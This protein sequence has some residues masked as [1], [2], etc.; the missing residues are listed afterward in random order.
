MILV[1]FLLFLV[2]L[3][4]SLQLSRSFLGFWFFV[5]FV[6]AEFP[7]VDALDIRCK[8]GPGLLVLVDFVSFPLGTLPLMAKPNIPRFVCAGGGGLG[9]RVRSILTCFFRCEEL[10]LSGES[11][12]ATTSNFFFDFTF[13]PS[14]FFDFV[15]IVMVCNAFITDQNSANRNASV[16]PVYNPQRQTV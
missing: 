9:V 16:V 12:G 1:S 6:L 11:F 4:V 10:F 3:P 5:F 2:L 8:K 7:G 15:G 14:G 13:T